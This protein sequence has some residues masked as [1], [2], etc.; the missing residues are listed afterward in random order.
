MNTDTVEWYF[1]NAR[2]MVGG[3]TNKLI[4]AGFDNA[5]KKSQLIQRSKY[6][7]SW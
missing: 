5:D 1:G 2:Q 4:A 6:G 3:S 7:Y